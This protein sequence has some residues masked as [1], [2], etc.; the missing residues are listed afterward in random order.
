M[1]LP[2]ATALV[3]EYNVVIF[4][5]DN[6][7]WR[8]EKWSHN[9]LFGSSVGAIPMQDSLHFAAWVVYAEEDHGLRVCKEYCSGTNT[10]VERDYM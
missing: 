10:S 9:P 8:S 5:T 1:A 3:Y 4:V 2:C 7:G 6:N